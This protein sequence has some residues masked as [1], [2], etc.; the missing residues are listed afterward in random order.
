V[1]GFFRW[2][3]GRAPGHPPRDVLGVGI[4]TPHTIT[5]AI[6]GVGATRPLFRMMFGVA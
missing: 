1:D 6:V 5:G 3:E 4:S 2:I